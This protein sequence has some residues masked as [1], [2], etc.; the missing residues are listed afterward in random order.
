[1]KLPVLSAPSRGAGCVARHA[2][3]VPLGDNRGDAE[4]IVSGCQ[5]PRVQFGVEAK[6]AELVAEGLG[7]ESI[8]ERLQS[9][10]DGGSPCD[11][12]FANPEDRLPYH[13]AMEAEIAFYT[14]G[15][16][17]DDENMIFL[18]ELIR[19]NPDSYRR[20][21]QR[22]RLMLLLC[23]LVLNIIVWVVL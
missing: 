5:L 16:A 8:R 4:L 17:G 12:K 10:A 20:V 13:E 23:L 21:N 15:V 22:L 1:M 7:P 2:A 14:G 11:M 3:V 18:I 9:W 6:L 19:D